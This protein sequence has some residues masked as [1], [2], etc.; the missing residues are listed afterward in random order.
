MA[1]GFSAEHISSMFFGKR[2]FSQQTHVFFIMKKILIMYL[3][4]QI[5]WDIKVGSFFILGR[6]ELKRWLPWLNSKT[7]NH[8]T[9]KF[10]SKNLAHFTNFISLNI[11]KKHTPQ[12]SQKSYSLYKFSRKHVS[13][14][15][16]KKHLYCT[17]SRRP[18]EAFSKHLETKCL[19]V[20]VYLRRKILF[21]R[22]RKLLSGEGM[23]YCLKAIMFCNL[24][25]VL[26]FLILIEIFGNL[27]IFQY[28][29]TSINSIE[30]LKF[31]RQ[32]GIQG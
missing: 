2:F 9:I 22:R 16:Q 27:T 17:I 25:N 1:N 19:Y 32:F 23:N 13:G 10:C 12:H 30:T 14:C 4:H 5:K 20:P 31:S 15:S 11:V 24:E 26:K 18:K 6:A 28:F 8:F 21:Q 7:I 29:Y 3:T